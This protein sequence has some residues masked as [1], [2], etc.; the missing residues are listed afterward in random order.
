LGDDSSTLESRLSLIFRLTSHWKALVLLDE[1]DVFVQERS[2]SHSAN[3]LVSVFLRKLEYFQGV[4]FMT[5]NRVKTFDEAIKSRITLALKYESL[6]P[7]TRLVIWKKFLKRA[8]TPSGPAVCKSKVLDQFA[9][10][11]LNGRQVGV[12]LISRRQSFANR[13]L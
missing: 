3:G 4:M 10:K 11:P 5:T 7:A 6:S 12:L 13:E 9:Q 8:T 1:A 2:F